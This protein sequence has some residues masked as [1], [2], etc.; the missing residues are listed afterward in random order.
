MSA[1][2]ILT[3][4]IGMDDEEFNYKS[5]RKIQQAEKQSTIIT[6]IPNTF[7]EDVQLFRNDLQNKLKN[8]TKQKRQMLL[9]DE[10]QNIEKIITN[11]YE[12]REKKIIMA[13]MTRIR[14]GSPAVK[15]LLDPELQLFDSLQ[16][17][18]HLTRIS[19]LSEEKEM[20]D[21]SEEVT[22]NHPEE[23]KE[24]HHDEEKTE[25]QPS[26]EH[27]HTLLRVVKDMPTFVGTDAKQYTIKEGDILSVPKQMGDMLIKRHVA[28]RIEMKK[29]QN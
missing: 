13:A 16:R 10:I 27:D 11:I 6:K 23:L 28:E 15:Y 20:I 3:S 8:E 4:G 26:I 29:A 9:A 14:G 22:E 18:L 5:L 17:L 25:E 21:T 19:L 1:L 2:D 24:T 7:Y 12:Q